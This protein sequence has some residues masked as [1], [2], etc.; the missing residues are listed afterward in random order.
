MKCSGQTG[1]KMA[2][3]VFCICYCFLLPMTVLGDKHLVEGELAVQVSLDHFHPGL[4]SL[5]GVQRLRQRERPYRERDYDSYTLGSHTNHSI[6]PANHGLY[7]Q[8]YSATTKRLFPW[9]L[10]CLLPC[11]GHRSCSFCLW[12][13]RAVAST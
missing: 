9:C 5:L 6:S 8:R 12:L 10:L 4:Q 1:R 7:L 2:P 11:R 3:C 13:H